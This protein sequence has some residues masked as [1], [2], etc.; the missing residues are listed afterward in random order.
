VPPTPYDPAQAQ[1]LLAA[2]GWKNDHGDGLLYKNGQ[3]LSFTLLYPSGNLNGE[4]EAELIQESLKAQGIDMELS[5]M[6]FAQLI[7]KINDW[8]F[9]AV[10]AGWSLDINGDP[11]QLWNSPDADVKKSSNFI[12][13]KNPVA[14][15]LML[16]AKT[17]YDDD[18]RFAI[19]RHLQQVIHDDYPV[20]FLTNPKVILLIDDRF[21][22]VHM[23]LPRPCFDMM[24]WWVPRAL[25]KYGN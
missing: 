17:E 3:P 9:D 1:Q 4:K 13:Y 14:D 6:E 21:Q 8:R 15:Q 12:G 7:D 22:N 24:T 11:W 18:K 23:F 10:L 20:C 25:Q 19:Y 2:A 16:Q 5:R